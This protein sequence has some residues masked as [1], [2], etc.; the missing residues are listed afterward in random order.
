[1]VLDGVK[2]KYESQKEIG[3]YSD[4][5]SFSILKLSLKIIS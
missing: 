1:M 2:E 5:S 4:N 3:F